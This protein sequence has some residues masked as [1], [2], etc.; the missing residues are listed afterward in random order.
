MSIQLARKANHLNENSSSHP[1]SW[2]THPSFWTNHPIIMEN[3][4]KFQVTSLKVLENSTNY[5][6]R[7]INFSLEMTKSPL[8]Y[9]LGAGIYRALHTNIY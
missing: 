8:C 6:G 5:F 3:S 1:N 9:S 2:T 4:P 7:L